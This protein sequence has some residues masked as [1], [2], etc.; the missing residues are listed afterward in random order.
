MATIYNEIANTLVTGTSD[1]DSI[2]NTATSVTIQA[3]GGDDYVI[4][5]VDSSVTAAKYGNLIEAGAGNDTVYNHHTYNPTIYGGAGNDSIVV[6]RGHKTFAHGGSGNDTILGVLANNPDNDWRMGGYATLLGGDGDDYIAPGYSDNSTINGGEGND[7]IITNGRNATID[8]GAGN[9]S[10]VLTTLEGG[11]TPQYVVLK[12]NTTVEGFATGFGDGSDTV[13]IHTENDPAG[14]ELKKTGLTFGNDTASLTLSDVKTTAKVN[15]F[16]ENRD[17][18]NKAVFIAKDDWYKVSDSDLTVNAGEEVYFVGTSGKLNH[19]VDFSGINADL[20]VTIDTAYIDSEDYVENTPFWVNGVY[21]IKGGAGNTTIT[22]SEKSDTIIA[23]AGDTTI[24]AG[25]GNDQISLSGGN[26]LVK[27]TAGDGNDTIY[28]FNSTST[29]SVGDSVYSTL[30]SGNDLIITIGESKLTL[31]NAATVSNPNIES[32][33]PVAQLVESI[34]KRTAAGYP[35]IAGLLFSPEEIT[36]PEPTNYSAKEDWTITSADN[37]KLYG[38][39][40]TPE[41][42]GDKWVVLVHGYGCMYESMNP[43]AT[44]YLANNYNVLMI[45]QRAAGKSEGTWLT[46]GAAESQDVALWTQEI[47]RRNSN[48]KITLHGVSMGSATAM[49]AA[50]RSDVKNVT[51]LIE[52]CGYS[53]AMEIFYLLNE[54]HIGVPAEVVAALDPVGK[55]MTGYYLHDAAPIDSIS[56]AKMPTLFISGDDDGVVPVS[57]LS[58]LYD[59][60]GASVKEKFIVEGAGHA[61]AGLNNPVEYSNTV[62]RFIAE[63]NGEGWNTTNIADDIS[64]RG[65]KY[66]DTIENSGTNVTIQTFGGDD[67][68]YNN[69]DST[70]TAE[71]YGNLIETGDGSDSVYSNHSYNPTIYG[72]TGDDYIAIS[73][74][75]KTFADG[76]DGNDTIIGTRRDGQKSDW[77]MGGY[78]TIFG[79][80]GDDYIAPGYSDNSTINGG[81]GNDT[82]ITNGRN[83]TVDGGAGNNSIVLT[84]TEGGATSQYIV[85]NGKTTVEGFKT[86]F[87]STSDKIYIPD[88]FPGVDFKTDGLT[89]YYDNDKTKSLTFSDITGTAPI[90][91]YY[92]PQDELSANV[93]I[94]DDEWYKAS[95]SDFTHNAQVYYVGA[96]AKLN[97]GIDF[98]GIKDDLNVTLNTDYESTTVKLWVNNIHSIKGGAG[99]TTITGSD[100]SDTII[101]GAG[102]TTINAGAGNDQISLSSGKA[103]VEYA[104]GDGSDIIRGFDKNS[105]LKISGDIFTSIQSG[106]DVILNVGDGKISLVGAATL[107]TLNID[108][109]FGV[110]DGDN[111]TPGF[112]DKSPIMISDSVVTV[113]ASKKFTAVEVV[114]NALDNT[115]LGGWRHDT[116]RGGD[117]NDLLTGGFGNDKLNGDAGDDTLRGGMGNDKLYGGAGDDLLDGGKGNDSLW[118]DA[119]ADTFVHGKFDGDDVI[120][121]FANDD[122]LQITGAF[123]TSY[124]SAAGEVKFG[125]GDGSITLRDFTAT[126]FNVNGNSYGISGN[127]LIRNV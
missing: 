44:F 16:H 73:R 59:A 36:G 87:D 88:E 8:G 78:A 126:S 51:S 84:T 43:F 38:V 66:N 64:L 101:A 29:L 83:A 111:F 105:T 54:A 110:G 81:N 37:L 67:L 122:L 9:N 77:T 96:T 20:N 15:L 104:T 40:Y 116:L 31:K 24:N 26:A 125:V 32:D 92:A 47:A 22:G 65:T 62:F 103:L 48:A 90:Y 49:L 28:G 79:G 76:G 99:L 23:G 109:K 72:G 50:S 6:S 2:T 63:A 61:R 55:G 112:L 95:S 18:L 58:E 45:D 33:N 3:L 14:V 25:A 115:I 100:K 127:K 114:G 27:Y 97:H 121:G 19:G 41:N 85:L 108:G 60:S 74:G 10:I 118:G 68:I 123:T 75:H 69:V 71:E 53:S 52:D 11:A 21:S 7:T 4:N 117:G 5:N 98:S 12:G 119:G 93:F 102:S 94:A 56:S 70:V 106:D 35:V 113:D 46:M 42:S 1:A 89:F 124:D 82:I 107:S 91:M 80:N 34:L 57:M 39:H 120:F 13:Y 17:V 86:G 30:V